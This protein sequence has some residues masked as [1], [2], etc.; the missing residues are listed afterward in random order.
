MGEGGVENCFGARKEEV[1]VIRHVN[2]VCVRVYRK[3]DAWQLE[4]SL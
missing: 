3:D 4:S 1:R 2:G